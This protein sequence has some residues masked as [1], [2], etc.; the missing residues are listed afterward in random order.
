MSTVH[1]GWWRNA[2]SRRARCCWAGSLV[3]CVVAT[4]C[5]S[6]E[7]AARRAA[8]ASWQKVESWLLATLQQNPSTITLRREELA[9]QLAS[10]SPDWFVVQRLETVFAEADVYLDDD[11]FDSFRYAWNRW[12]QQLAVPTV[13]QIAAAAT[14]AATRDAN[15]SAAALE[16]ARRRFSNELAGLE[17][18]LGR[19]SSAAGWRK[20]LKLPELKAAV[21]DADTLRREWSSVD[22]AANRWRIASLMLPVADVQ[23]TTQS[24]AKLAAGARVVMDPEFAATRKAKL[25]RLAELLARQEDVQQGVPPG[26]VGEI[27]HWLQQRDVDR[28][29]VAAVERRFVRPNFLVRVPAAG[30]AAELDGPLT[31]T[32]P[33]NEVI[34]GTRVRGTGQLTAQLKSRFMPRVSQGILE[35]TLQ[36]QTVASTTGYPRGFTVSSTG[37]TQLSGTKRLAIDPGGIRPLRATTKADTQ[38]TYN[39]IDTPNTRYGRGVRENVHANRRT[40]ERESADKAAAYARAKLDGAVDPAAAAFNRVLRQRIMLPLAS[41]DVWPQTHAIRSDASGLML[42]LLQRTPG[43]FVPSTPPPAVATPANP[44]I[45]VHASFPEQ[46]VAE[47]VG[48]KTLFG[49]ELRQWLS[50][51]DRPAATTE[52][53]DE[54]SLSFPDSEAISVSFQDDSAHIKLRLSGFHAEDRDFPPMEVA[55][56]YR[57]HQIGDRLKLQRVGAFDVYPLG[58]VRGEQRLS[59]PQLAVRDV[60]RRRLEA[61]VPHDFDLWTMWDPR[62]EMRVKLS[63]FSI[64]QDW[65]C[66]TIVPLEQSDQDGK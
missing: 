64:T 21:R 36:G 29:L 19:W 49:P 47:L 9:G 16:I 55:V 61:N 22:H 7:P 24:L 25:A 34:A 51:S 33:V 4:E 52:P 18:R 20:Y 12:L 11:R 48:G 1:V 63:G 40:A 2:W 38:I 3:L 56:Q 37:V 45:L 26:E 27:C 17:I 5:Q 44:Q 46:L 57:I 50:T 41:R 14:A 54:W 30:L 42:A 23:P 60:L 13:E 66:L 39:G 62:Q 10:E 6:Q 31:E 32:F 53:E 35:V 59:G 28:D 43:H 58:F 8:A 15:L 65:L